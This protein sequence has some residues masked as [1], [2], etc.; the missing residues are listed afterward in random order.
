MHNAI[1]GIDIAKGNFH[2]VLLTADAE[3]HRS[4]PN[5]AKGFA[6]LH[7][8]LR[9]RKVAQVHACMESTG[10]YGE[11]LA[12]ELHEHGHVVSIVNPARIKGFAQSELAR[13]KTDALDAG[14]IARFCK[15]LTPPP[16]TPPRP[17]IRALQALTRRLT[18]LTAA[19]Q[20]EC[21]R[22]GVPGVVDSVADSIAAHIA[23]LDAQI[24]ALEEQ[25][26]THIDQHPT[27]RDRR[28]LLE[29]IPGLGDKTAARILGELPDVSH[30]ASAKQ[31]SAY[32]GLSPRHVQS[33]A[34]VRWRPRLSKRGNT[35]LRK[36]LY[37]PAIVAIM[38]NPVLRRFAE[39][40][41]AAGKSK[42]LIIGAVMRKLVHIAY[43][44]LK[45]HTPFDPN[46]DT[47]QA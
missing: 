41:R 34:S 30:F 38:H 44:V 10:A 37:F 46:Y 42:M 18:S 43:G 24:R 28:D 14:V 29:S 31:L 39:R 16:W 4:F 45:R 2:A 13:N 40:L 12:V 8:W 26:R 1:V 11:A 5:N 33:G 23:H 35:H 32:I 27:L 22:A 9:N 36:A 7:A 47:A 20:Q 17:E 19:R 15:A 6:Q 21:N 25:I 3:H